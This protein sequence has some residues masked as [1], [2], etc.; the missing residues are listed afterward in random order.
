MDAKD[1]KEAGAKF[2][3]P[4]GDA[5]RLLKGLT[6]IIPAAVE[7]AHALHEHRQEHHVHTHQ[8]RPKVEFAETV[9]HEAPGDFWIPVID[10]SKE[11]EDRSGGHHIVEV[12]NH[13][14]G[15]VQRKVDEIECQRQTGQTTDTEHRQ[16][17][18][19]E[20]HLGIEADGSTPETDHQ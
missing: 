17:G 4:V 15:I 5:G 2:A 8:R 3:E 9:A 20:K 14:V 13:I 6:S 1:P 12:A 11:R 10:A 16:E 7:A 18:G 19:S